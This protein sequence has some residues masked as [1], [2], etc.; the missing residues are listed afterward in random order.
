MAQM[1]ALPPGRPRLALHSQPAPAARRDAPRNP[2]S[3]PRHAREVTIESLR[4]KRS[5]T[6]LR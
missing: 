2:V 1:T 5:V 3:A 6:W 4:E